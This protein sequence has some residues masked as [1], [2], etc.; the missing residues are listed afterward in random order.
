MLNSQGSPVQSSF[1]IDAPVSPSVPP[2]ISPSVLPP[3]SPSV[4][5][6]IPVPPPIPPREPSGVPPSA[7]L[8]SVCG[9][10]IKE[11]PRNEDGECDCSAR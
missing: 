7:V 11:L 6:P 9:Q 2:P 1:V 3:I 8:C 10:E 5:L 4:L